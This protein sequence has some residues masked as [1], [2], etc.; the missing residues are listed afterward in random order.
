MALSLSEPPSAKLAI[1]PQSRK[2]TAVDG[3]DDPVSKKIES[4]KRETQKAVLCCAAEIGDKTR[5]QRDYFISYPLQ[6]I[7]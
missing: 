3:L 5:L 7:S 2:K 4:G 1:H 6:I